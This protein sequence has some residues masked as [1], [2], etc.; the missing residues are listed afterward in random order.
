M[1]KLLW[2]LGI[3][4]LPAAE[5][6]AQDSTA[7]QKLLS[8]FTSAYF[9]SEKKRPSNSYYENLTEAS[10]ILHV[11]NSE[12]KKAKAD[13]KEFYRAEPEQRVIE[14][15]ADSIITSFTQSS[16]WKGLDDM[17]I[18][19]R[20]I[21]Q[22]VYGKSCPCYSEQYKKIQKLD[23]S[24]IAYCDSV[25]LRDV[26][27]MANLSLAMSKIPSRDFNVLPSLFSRYAYQHCK[28]MNAALNATI[29]AAV[30][31]QYDYVV[32]DQAFSIDEKAAGLW[33]RGK[34]DSLRVLFPGYSKYS[35]ELKK[36]S[37]LY[38][39]EPMTSNRSKEENGNTVYT[40][41]FIQNNKVTGR[42]IYT[43]SVNDDLV[44]LL[45]FAF[46]PAKKIPAAERRKLLNDAS[47][48]ILPPLQTIRN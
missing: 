15:L 46:V 5:L 22:M 42:V 28:S 26:A 33:E 39:G 37:M 17:L 8:Q 47:G 19:H 12:F 11:Y 45:E 34:H 29:Y 23:L 24:I 30:V 21:L 41:N 7:F 4:L 18:K 2:S 14:K 10:Y 1:R 3:V 32:Q 9:D 13:L 44:Q 40:K 43:V 27:F 31:D 16:L 6:I 35:S 38:E 25:T 48:E 20:N 36:A